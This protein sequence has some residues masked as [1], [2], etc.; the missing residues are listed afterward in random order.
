LAKRTGWF[1]PGP[2]LQLVALRIDAPEDES[3][4]GI[5]HEY[6]HLITQLN[7]GKLPICLTEGIAEFFAYSELSENLTYLGKVKPNAIESPISSPAR[8]MLSGILSLRLYRIV[9]D[10]C[11]FPGAF[12]MRRGIR[13]RKHRNHFHRRTPPGSSPGSLM[14]DPQAPHPK[15]MVTAYSPESEIE[16]T[17]SDVES[18]RSYLSKWPVVWINVEGLGDAETIRNLGL[19]FDLH[20]LALEDVINVHQRPKVEIYKSQYFIVVRMADLH[21]R[22]ET[23]QLAIFLGKNYVLTFQETGSGRFDPIRTRI[24]DIGG[25]IRHSGADYLAY[26]ILD[27]CI[28]NYFPAL[29]KYGEQIESLE[30]Q[31]ILHPGNQF[32]SEIHEM[33]RDLLTLRRAVWPLR[34][35]VNSLIR[36][37]SQFLTDETRIYMRDCYDHTIQVIDLLE[38]YRDIAGDLIEVYLSSVS[39]RLNEIMKILTIFTTIFIPLNFIAGIYGMNFKNMPELNWHYGY[40]Y[41]L[42]IM[43]ALTLGMFFYFRKKGWWGPSGDPEKQQNPKNLS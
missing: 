23:Q 20:R 30:D 16:E 32:V 24:R 38:N 41:A 9:I 18:I 4:H 8:L 42:G 34:E 19:I 40:L 14:I 36:E 28:D 26:A 11:Y 43:T 35:A 6:V 10:Y 13:S 5:Y 21:D 33:K 37:P 17:I 22:L 39:N 12:A 29:E 7:Y 15:I 31:V 27:S 1:L 2:E 3:Y 25:R